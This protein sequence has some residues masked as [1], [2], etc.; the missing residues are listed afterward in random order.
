MSKIPTMTK[1]FQFE[2][3]ILSAWNK[4]ICFIKDL[5]LVAYN[6]YYVLEKFAM[7]YISMIF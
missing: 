1:V 3:Y 5:F 6:N 7:R 4:I 2:S